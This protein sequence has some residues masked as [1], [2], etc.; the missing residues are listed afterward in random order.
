L[1]RYAAGF[2]K[3]THFGNAVFRFIGAI[4]AIYQVFLPTSSDG[5]AASLSPSARLDEAQFVRDRGVVI[6]LLVPFLWLVWHR[7]WF[8]F[9]VYCLF[10]FFLAGIGQTDWAI[11]TVG[12]S[13]LPGLY[14]FLEGTNLIAAKLTGKGWEL[15]DL[16]EADSLADAEY[17]FYRRHE[18]ERDAMQPDGS[19]REDGR[20][21]PAVYRAPKNHGTEFGMFAEN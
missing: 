4:M 1:C 8:G 6:A 16:V 11:L 21:Q 3:A 13:F 19:R 9:A 20:L 14:L 15:F 10:A 12:L 5:G 17:M 2:N 7:L 18:M